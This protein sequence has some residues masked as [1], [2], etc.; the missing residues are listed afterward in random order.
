MNKRLILVSAMVAALAVYLVLFPF[1]DSV[2]LRKAF[3]EFPL[4]WDGWSGDPSLLDDTSLEMLKMSEYMLRSY[5]KEKESVNIYIGYYG[6]QRGGSQIHSPKLCLPAGG[7]Q[8]VSEETR[9]MD[10]D[11]LGAVNVVQALYQKG[12]RKE[13]FVYWY[14][15]KGAYITGE[16]RLRFYRFFNSLLY[17]RND[18]AFIR[19]SAPVSGGVKEAASSIEGFMGDFLPVLKDYLPE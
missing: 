12:E 5:G 18:A 7:W 11:G 2:P 9:S 4:V 3:A 13:L 1:K 10:I 6:S 16:Y 8:K 14:Q 17:R 19:L 15:M